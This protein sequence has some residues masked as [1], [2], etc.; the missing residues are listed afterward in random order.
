MSADGKRTL[1]MLGGSASQVVAIDRARELGYRTVLCDYLPDNPGQY[2]ADTFYQVSTTDKDAVMQVARSENIDGVVA[3]GS[4]PAAP[5]AAYVAEQLDLPGIPYET[6]KSFCEKHL[7]RGFLARN[8]FCVPEHWSVR[9]EDIDDALQRIPD[10]HYPLIVK[11]TDS[12]GS[13][14][15]TVVS[16]SEELVPALHDAER[17]S[18][19][20][21]LEIE[22]FIVAC[23]PGVIEGE[24]FVYDGRVVS[25]GLMNCLRDE[26][27][28][29]LLP[30]GYRHPLNLAQQHI[31][32][33]KNEIQRLVDAGGIRAGAM[34]IEM[35]LTEN[36]KLY[37]LDAGPRN[38]GNMLPAFFSRISGDDLVEGTLRVA[39]GESWEHSQ[40]DG[41]NDGAWYMHVLHVRERGRF[42]RVA[43]SEDVKRALV[44][45]KQ[46]VQTGDEVYP[47]LTSDKLLGILMMHFD[48]SDTLDRV[49]SDIDQHIKVVLEH[50]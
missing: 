50:V 40:F 22:Q 1:L 45:E 28:N 34:N 18:R 48:D 2:H 8:S 41:A 32:Q 30:A 39:M 9:V 21:V 15:V 36:G 33:I 35:M 38:G 26:Q 47:F 20:G 17:F 49:L 25:W 4:D 43:Y 31:E 42:S 44:F 5:T 6:A 10:A 37:F 7:F 14:G 23:H 11:P 16:C 13:K 3:Y 27:I 29:P 46:Y 12:S 24:L 19:N